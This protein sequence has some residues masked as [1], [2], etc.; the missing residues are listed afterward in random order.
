MNFQTGSGF[1]PGDNPANPIVP[2]LDVAE[3]E[4]MRLES[5]RQL[6][7]CCRWLEEKF[8]ALE[9]ADNHQ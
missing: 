6:E 4:E 1:N 8:R 2:D 9:N 7:E 5:S 3:G